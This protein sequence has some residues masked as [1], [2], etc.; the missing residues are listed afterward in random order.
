MSRGVPVARPAKPAASASRP[1]ASRGPVWFRK[2]D[3]NGDGYVSRREFLGPKDLFDKLDTDGDGLIGPEE[4][5]GV[6]ALMKND[7]RAP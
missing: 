5:E 1:A 6:D 2:M 4:A 7:K 3:H